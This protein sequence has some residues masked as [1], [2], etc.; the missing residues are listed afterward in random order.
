MMRVGYG[1]CLLDVLGPL[2]DAICRQLN[3]DVDLLTARVGYGVVVDRAEVAVGLV[4]G[5]ELVEL[6]VQAA[7]VVE[8]YAGAPCGAA[9]G[10]AREPDARFTGRCRAGAGLIRGGCAICIAPE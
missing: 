8:L 7:L 4:D 10:G 1:L 9:V 5:E 2:Y 3:V 6:V